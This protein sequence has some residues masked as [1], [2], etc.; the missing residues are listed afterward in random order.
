MSV[1]R[2]RASRGL[3][4][5]EGSSDDAADRTWQIL[6]HV[7]DENN[8][9]DYISKD[10]YNVQQTAGGLPQNMSFE[11]FLVAVAGHVRTSLQ[12]SS[13]DEDLSDDDFRTACLSFDDVIRRHVVFLNGVVHQAAPGDVHMKLWNFILQS[14]D[15]DTSIYSLYRNYLVDA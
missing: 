9:D 6:N 7:L 8:S 13:F 14:R 5:F 2:D 1:W 3:T 12:G 10:F 11:D 15:L 4:M